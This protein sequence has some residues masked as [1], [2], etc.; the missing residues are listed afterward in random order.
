[1]YSVELLSISRSGLLREYSVIRNNEN[2]S[3][4]S[5]IT[6]TRKTIEG[7]LKEILLEI[8]GFKF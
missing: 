8:E 3:S 1:M 5:P 2:E 4:H 7:K 6:E